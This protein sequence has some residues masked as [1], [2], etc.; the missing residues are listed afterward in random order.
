MLARRLRQPPAAPISGEQ[1]R[2]ITNC[3]GPATI[4]RDTAALARLTRSV[5]GI[6]GRRFPQVGSSIKS[7][8]PTAKPL[9][10][11]SPI[12]EAKSFQTAGCEKLPRITCNSST[13]SMEACCMGYVGSGGSRSHVCACI[14]IGLHR[15]RCEFGCGI[16]SRKQGPNTTRVRPS[17]KHQR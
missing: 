10:G 4:E 2:P 9:S 12:R 8:G 3:Q 5:S 7:V 15:L 11:P 6:N 13:V 16:T 17:T 1:P 14:R